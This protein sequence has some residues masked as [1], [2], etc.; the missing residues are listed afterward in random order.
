[1]PLTFAERER[2]TVVMANFDPRIGESTRFRKGGPSPNP[3]GRPKTRLLSEALRVRLAEPVPGDS[4]GR[5]YAEVLAANLI[6][7]ACSHG[8]GAVAAMG[9]IAD[10]VEGKARQEIAVADI[11]LELREK[12]DSELMFHLD[13]GRWPEGDELSES[14]R[15]GDQKADK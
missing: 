14:P 7:I 13:H 11:T 5:T 12:S 8:P 10:R 4:E 2:I 9:E 15:P 3:G 1:M 6:T